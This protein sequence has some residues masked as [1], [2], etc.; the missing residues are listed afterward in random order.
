MDKVMGMRVFSAVATN[1]S[2]SDAAKKLSI[3]KA[4]VSKHVQNLENSLGVR[5]FNRTTRKLNLTD[6]GSTY[7]AKVNSILADIDET[8]SL[9]SQINSEPKGKLKIVAQPSFGAFHLSRALSLYLKKYNDVTAHI[10]LSQRIPDLVEEGID[11]AFHVGALNDSMYISRRIASARRVICASP[12]YIEENGMPKKPE[13]LSNHNC[14][15]YMPHDDIG[16]WEFYEKGRRKKIKVSGDIQCNSGDALRIASIQGC[17][18]AQLPTYMIGLDIQAGR[19][20]A[21]LEDFEPEKQPIYAIYNHRN[22]SAKIKTFIDFIYDLYQ[23]E[24][25]WN[26]WT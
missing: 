2:F 16:K 15:I 12:E 17:G 22:V 5:L 25:Y 26:E 18:I 14:L 10:E 20:R 11:L 1:R 9:I 21:L 4:M 8:E 23:P 24:P 13:D 6:V 3:S 19:L 7:Y